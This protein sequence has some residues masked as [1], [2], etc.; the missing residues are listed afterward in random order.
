MTNF[1][2]N[3]ELHKYPSTRH[4]EGSQ[5]QQGDDGF[6]KPHKRRDPRAAYASLA[7]RT[8]VVEEKLDGANAG[9]SF[10]EGAELLLQSRGHY[11]AGGGR[12]RQFSIFKRWAAAHESALLERLGDRYVMY[13]EWMGK[14]H[15]VFYNRLPHLFCEFDIYDRHKAVFLSTAARAAL[16][17]DAPVLAVPVLYAGVAPPRLA[18][19]K[20]LIRCSLAKSDRWRHDFEATVAREGLDL[21]TCWA[22]AD[23]SDLAEGLY[24]KVEEDGVV[25]ARYKWVRGDFVQA[26]LDAKMH[27]SQ[28][29]YVPNQLAPGV[30]IYAPRLTT[31]WEDLGLVTEGAT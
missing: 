23:K 4:L 8:I 14:K 31:T 17:G 16:L 7:G 9:L 10:S 29:P 2:H 26:I 11:L 30:D 27:H 13:G 25:T 18:D 22:Q 15:S 21:A 20:A 1:V 19:L 5:L 3:L 6:G 28:Q 24:I 12:E